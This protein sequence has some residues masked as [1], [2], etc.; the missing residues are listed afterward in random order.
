MVTT[1]GESKE[2][3][4]DVCGYRFID[5]GI[6]TRFLTEVCRTQCGNSNLVLEENERERTGC[7]PHL[8][9]RCESCASECTFYTSTKPR[10]TFDVNKRFVY[11]MRSLCEGHSQQNG[12]VN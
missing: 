4:S 5:M 2:L 10:Y 8:I 3:P 12:F 6:L 1:S 11:A 9:V 7:A